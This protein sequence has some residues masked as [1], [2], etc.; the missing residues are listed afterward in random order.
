MNKK[1]EE[2]VI[3]PKDLLF[4]ALYR[5]KAAVI[6]GLV[7]AI[8]LGGMQLTKGL[9]IGAEDQAAQADYEQALKQ[10]EEKKAPLE[11]YIEQCEEEIRMQERYMQESVYLSLDPYAHYR[12][13]IRMFVSTDYQIQ[14]DK[15]Y[16]TPDLTG[17]LLVAYQANLQSD[18]AVSTLA[19][20]ADM[21]WR[22]LDEIYDVHFDAS[23]GA[24]MVMIV[25][26]DP[27][28]V[29]KLMDETL[30]IIEEQRI[31]LSQT[32]GQHTLSVLNQE[33][34]LVV[35]TRVVKA[36]RDNWTHLNY[37]NEEL[38]KA[39]TATEDLTPPVQPQADGFS[40]KKTAIFAILG[41]VAGFAVV[42][43]CAWF[44]HMES[45]K[46][47][48][49][50][51]L[52]IR[53][54]IKVLG[55]V[56]ATA[57]GPVDRMIRKWEGRDTSDPAK[58]VALLTCDIRNR[59]PKGKLL[60]TGSGSREERAAILQAL[61]AAGVNATDEGCILESPLAVELLKNVDAVVLA[62]KCGKA[63]CTGVFSQMQTVADYEKA[64]LGCIVLDG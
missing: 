56:N 62:E 41:F 43:V 31:L 54:G 17:H 18:S 32:V 50:R 35:D 12:G 5:W 3:Y 64:L 29:Q 42:A 37:L 47:Y 34:N 26:N 59:F 6:L 8:L 7:L 53:T 40:V 14:P 27:A 15:T 51:L 11:K 55:T 24:L 38:E 21:Q 39:K 1:L 46:V 10:Y 30:N 16:Q 52:Q 48:S 49:A 25:H 63:T 44:G 36:V 19:E 9:N 22:L 2:Q 20:T 28:M 61:K 23:S 4:A 13:N 33:V 57:F 45:D 60:L 58:K